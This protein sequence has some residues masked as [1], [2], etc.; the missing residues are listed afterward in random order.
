MDIEFTEEASAKGMGITVTIKDT[1]FLYSH[2]WGSREL[3]DS[4]TAHGSVIARSSL[5]S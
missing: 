1:N 2:T 4:V 5:A 3:Y